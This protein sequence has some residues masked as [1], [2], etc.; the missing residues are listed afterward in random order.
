MECKILSFL[1]NINDIKNVDDKIL[2]KAIAMT[3]YRM[4]FT[5]F[6][7]LEML[8]MVEQYLVQHPD[9]IIFSA[10]VHACTRLGCK[11]RIEAVINYCSKIINK[12]FT[13]IKRK[14][15]IHDSIIPGSKYLTMNKC[16]ITHEDMQ[17]ILKISSNITDTDINTL[18][19]HSCAERKYCWHEQVDIEDYVNFYRMLGSGKKT[20]ELLHPNNV[21]NHDAKHAYEL[22]KIDFEG[23][24][25][26][27]YGNRVKSSRCG[28]IS[29]PGVVK[30]QHTRP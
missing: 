23:E 14:I 1:C 24:N 19:S 29:A 12:T 21:K 6:D 22:F 8:K 13:P 7:K 17:M 30:S 15:Y 26:S 25:N 5:G 4:N 9:P 11:S 28:A 3:N 20:L 10:Y 27:M 16:G 2:V 18:W